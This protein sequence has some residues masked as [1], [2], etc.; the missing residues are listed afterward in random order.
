LTTIAVRFIF[1]NV[2]DFIGMLD[3]QCF[4]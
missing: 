2:Y 3:D 4:V 1:V